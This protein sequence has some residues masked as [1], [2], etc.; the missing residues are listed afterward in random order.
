LLGR[1][2]ELKEAGAK[3]VVSAKEE[4]EGKGG[5]VPRESWELVCQVKEELEDVVK[6][7]KRLMR[8]K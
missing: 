2:K 5:R 3:T 4:E 7:E 1:V 6:Q 8:L